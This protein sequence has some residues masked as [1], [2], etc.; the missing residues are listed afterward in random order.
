[1]E[2]HLRVP[3]A[4]TWSDVD[5]IGPYR[6]RSVL[7]QGATGIVHQAEDPSRGAPVALKRITAAVP[8]GAEGDAAFLR[9]VRAAAL[10][11]HPNLATVIASGEF[12]ARPWVAVELVPGID[13]AQVRRS[14][15]AHP[16][17]WALDVWRQ[18]AE[19]LGHAHRS[20]LLHLD[21]KPSDVRVG[22]NGEVKVVDFGASCLKA[23]GRQGLPGL[24]YRAPEQ[25]EGRGDARSDVFASAAIVYELVA[26]QPVFA[27]EDAGAVTASLR[28]AEADPAPLPRTA[29]SPGFERILLKALAREPADRYASF[30]ELHADL[31]S[32]VK[33]TVP[34]LR[35]AAGQARPAAPPPPA[36]ARREA[37]L[38][39][40]ARARADGRLQHALALARALQGEHPANEA[41]RAALQQVEAAIQDREVDSLLGLALSYAADGEVE[42]AARIAEK[43]ERIAPWSPRYL[44]LQV[45]LDEESLRR[46]AD[47]LARVARECLDR[48]D[49]AG[50]REA[51][52]EALAL[53]PGHAVARRLLDHVHGGAAEPPPAPAVPAQFSPSPED[54]PAPAEIEQLVGRA[55]DHFLA[56]EHVQ[57]R[58][59]LGQALRLDPENRRAQELL[60]ILGSLG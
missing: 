49:R 19:G 48:G 55:L 1:M 39:E 35:A 16:F 33:E 11:T 43:V 4:L 5:T 6:I 18:L 45:Y 13:L 54:G 44:Q 8:R 26:R 9:Q 27:G 42:L 41:V 40:V 56:D 32:L 2:Y 50:A 7:G 58:R 59:T 28:T 23:P 20:G 25:L 12:D 38:A 53:M 21:L 47:A 34:R 29:F 3:K 60:Q 37:A 17:E 46:Q 51:A 31:V 10:L 52:E 22:V 24:R 57:A 15:K 30:A 36:D 14:G